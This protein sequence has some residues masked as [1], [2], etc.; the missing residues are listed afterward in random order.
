[1]GRVQRLMSQI[2]RHYADIT[3]LCKD[4]ERGNGDK[5]SACHQAKVSERSRTFRIT[6]EPKNSGRVDGYVPLQPSV[7]H[8]EQTEI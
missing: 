6:D 8:R 7:G 4:Y 5:N 2:Q 3:R 1:M